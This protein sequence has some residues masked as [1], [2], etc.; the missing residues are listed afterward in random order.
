MGKTVEPSGQGCRAAVT[1]DDL[2]GPL[3]DET[4]AEIRAAWLTCTPRRE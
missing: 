4:V 2:I 3:A 1:G